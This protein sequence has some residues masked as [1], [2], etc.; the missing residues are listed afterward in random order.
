MF[1]QHLYVS[2]V[3]QNWIIPSTSCS[4]FLGF[5][6]QRINSLSSCHRFSTGF[7]SGDSAGVRHQ[8]ILAIKKLFSGT[9]S[10]FWIIILHEAMWVRIV[11]MNEWQECLLKDVTVQWC[12]HDSF[13][14]AYCSRSFLTDP[15]PHVYLD[16]MF[17]MRFWARVFT[18][19]SVA[20]TTMS[21]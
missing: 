17:W 10:V 1:R 19:L 16:W 14:N 13:K 9:G 11:L 20:H 3:A 15:T 6:S 8:L 5:T 12:S 21:F 2:I 7:I 18:F 4:L